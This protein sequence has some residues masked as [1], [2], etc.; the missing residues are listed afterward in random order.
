MFLSDLFCDTLSGAGGAVIELYKTDG[1]LGAARGAGIGAGIYTS[2][3][4]AFA[5][6]SKR[7]EISPRPEVYA[8]SYGK[9][10]Q[11]LEKT[12]LEID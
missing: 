3:E 11:T 4:D 5:G 9:W 8:E 6:L 12:L 1:A 10:R 7:K 2:F